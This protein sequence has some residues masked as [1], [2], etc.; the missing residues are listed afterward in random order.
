MPRLILAVITGYLVFSI[1]AALFFQIT[2]QDPHVTPS[3][4]FGIVSVLYGIVCAAMAG[5]VAARFA[6]RSN[7]GASVAVG[8]LIAAGAVISL[9]FEGKHGQVWSQLSA[10]LLMAPSA[11]GGGVLYGKK[12]RTTT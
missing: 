8:V 11:Y 5:F 10:L 3:I 6:S 4:L 2:G 12:Q 1:S 9:V 7:L